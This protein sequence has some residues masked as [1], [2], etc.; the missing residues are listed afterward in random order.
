MTF[1]SL[2][3][4]AW[5][6][7]AGLGI[8]LWVLQFWAALPNGALRML[9]LIIQLIESGNYPMQL[10]I[11]LIGLLPKP[12]GGERPIA[13]TSMLYRLIIKLRRPMI[14]DW[15]ER[16]HG[17]W[18]AAIKGSSCLCAALARSLRMEAGAAMGLVAIGGLW[19][20][21]AFFDSIRVDEL[22]TLSLEQQFPP[23]ILMLAVNVHSSVRDFREGPY[24]SHWVQPTGLSILAGCGC[25]VD[26]T[27][28]LLYNLLDKLH[29]DYMPMQAST[30]VDDIAQTVLGPAQLAV[31]LAASSGL[32]LVRGLALH[33]LR[34]SPKSRYVASNITAAKA[35]QKRLASEGIHVDVG[36][37]GQDL[38]ADFVAGGRR[39]V[40]M[41]TTRMAKMRSGVTH[42]IRLGKC[43]K[44]TA[45]RRLILIGVKPRIYGFSV[46]GAAPTTILN[47]RT[48][49]VKGLCIRK[50]GGCATTALAMNGFSDKDPLLTMTTDNIVGF[51]EGARQEGGI[52]RI[53][54]RA[55]DHSHKAMPSSGKWSA[56]NGPMSSA[57]ATLSDL[58]W[59]LTSMDTWSDPEGSQWQ[60]DYKDPQLPD[61]VK[62][63]LQVHTMAFIW[64]H[65]AAHHYA[66]IAVQP[67]FTPYKLVKKAM[68]KKGNARER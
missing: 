2:G 10:L 67:D 12:K 22:V 52:T 53:L 55:W 58:D 63:L 19:D 68:V 23:Q 1:S 50:P 16:H 42:T 57:I 26:F 27:R 17:H 20:I 64:K 59:T 51:I 28:A 14:G 8:D 38:G 11:V 31:P 49:I 30:W 5:P 4:A 9:L 48:S 61:I 7:K 37:V 39:R 3:L 43:T 15:E 40:S 45:T 13:L 33:G 44:G 35:V 65:Y 6:A 34:I 54:Q 24:V 41:Q 32:A 62:E 66:G 18:D 29:R 36:V 60:L 47:V 46:L 56:V 25:S 21:S